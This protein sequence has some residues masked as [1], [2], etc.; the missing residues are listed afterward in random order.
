MLCAVSFVAAALVESRAADALASILT[1]VFGGGGEFVALLG[2]AMLTGLLTQ[3]LSATAVAALLH[4]V[5]MKMGYASDGPGHTGRLLAVMIIAVNTKY[6]LPITG[7]NLL[8]HEI[9]GYTSSDWF[10]FGIPTWLI[11]IAITA[12]LVPM[13]IP[14]DE[15]W[16][17]G[18][19]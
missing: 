14:D 10:R 8:I 16:P 19:H 12:V 18:C 7:G 4:P 5:V 9:G 17:T 11:V 6:I 3:V 15:H 13:I 1:R 2:V